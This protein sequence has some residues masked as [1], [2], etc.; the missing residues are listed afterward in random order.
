VRCV[1]YAVGEDDPRFEL[2]LSFCPARGAT[3]RFEGKSWVVSEFELRVEAAARFSQQDRDLY[4]RLELTGPTAYLVVWLTTPTGW[5]FQ[6]A[7]K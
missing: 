1:F 3:V 2:Q 4:D 7:R 5:A 6:S